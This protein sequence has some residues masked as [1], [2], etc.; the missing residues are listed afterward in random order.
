MECRISREKKGK[1][2]YV[3]VCDIA[4]TEHDGVEV[5]GLIRERQLL[6]IALHEP[7]LNMNSRTH[8]RLS[9]D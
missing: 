7:N 2:T 9:N 8:G 5:E 3:L 1:Y 4:Q 6:C